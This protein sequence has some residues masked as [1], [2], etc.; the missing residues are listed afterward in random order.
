M[1]YSLKLSSGKLD[2]ETVAYYNGQIGEMKGDLNSLLQFG[3]SLYGVVQQGVNVGPLAGSALEAIEAEAES[4][5]DEAKPMY[6]N[7]IAR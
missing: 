1:L 7:V 2:K 3:Y 6:F 5:P 4:V